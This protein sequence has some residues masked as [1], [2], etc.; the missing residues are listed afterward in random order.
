LDKTHRRSY[1][2]EERGAM[3]KYNNL[4]LVVFDFDGTIIRPK[5]D[6]ESLKR[7]LGSG[8]RAGV[9]TMCIRELI[10]A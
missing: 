6:W 4:G 8:K 3:E 9:R 1:D 7:E 5:V 10:E 2:P